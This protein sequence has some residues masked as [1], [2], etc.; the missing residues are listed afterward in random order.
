MVKRRIISVTLLNL[1][2]VYELFINKNGITI[3][4]LAENI[5]TDYKNTYNAV[6]FLFKEGIIKKEK[7]GNYNVCRLNYDND[8][9]VQYIAWHNFVIK[10][11]GF[12]KKH[13]L[14]YSIIMET[15]Q[16]L[17]GKII[18]SFICLVFG[19]HA[20]NQEKENSDIDILF[21]THTPQLEVI[22]KVLNTVNAPYQ[23]K[24]HLVEQTFSNFIKDLKNKDK[25]S[26]ATEICIEPPIVFYS[27]DVFF[28]MIITYGN[29][30]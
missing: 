13:N 2:I 26:I 23:K 7:I 27:N 3:K 15:I 5:S 30:K 1:K 8:D 22:K 25:L 20:K 10:I 14:E 18:P 24:F 29:I 16:S 4:N 28:R 11:D 12:K 21:I 9:I 17:I 19:S 6:D